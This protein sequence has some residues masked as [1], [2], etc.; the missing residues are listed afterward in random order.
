MINRNL[1]NS[2]RGSMPAWELPNHG[3]VDVLRK[4]QKKRKKYK[5]EITRT[6]FDRIEK[7][8]ESQVIDIN[9]FDAWK[10]TVIFS[11]TEKQRLWF[12]KYALKKDNPEIPKK[13]RATYWICQMFL[14]N[15]IE[16]YRIK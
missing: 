1:W 11:I 10:D 16:K 4:K 7:A 9:G 15:E 12:A 3:V 5:L 6:Q 13:L 14:S 2:S 8:F